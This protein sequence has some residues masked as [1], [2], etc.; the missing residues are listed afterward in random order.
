MDNSSYLS[1]EDLRESIYDPDTCMIIGGKYINVA[2]ID[3]TDHSTML[4]KQFQQQLEPDYDKILMKMFSDIRMYIEDE[5]L[6]L[7]ENLEFEEFRS[8]M[9]RYRS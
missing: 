5:G 7:C 8:F 6:D 9:M 3:E 2:D 1:D 4:Q